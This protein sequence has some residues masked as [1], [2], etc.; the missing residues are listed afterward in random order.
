MLRFPCKDTYCWDLSDSQVTLWQ[1]LYP[2]IE[3]ARECRKAWAWIDA[4]P[5]RRKLDG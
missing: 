3:V 5:A 1:E 4:S 2:D